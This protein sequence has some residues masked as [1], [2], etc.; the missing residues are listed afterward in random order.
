M[1]A[2]L[3]VSELTAL[4]SVAAADLFLIADDDASASKKVTLTNLEG[5]FSLANLG[6]RSIDNL[7]DV[8]TSG[9]SDGQYL[10]WS[11]SNSR[12]EPVNAAGSTVQTSQRS[13]DATHYLTFVDS[14]N[15]SPADESIYTD[16]GVTYNPSSNLLT[17]GEVSVTTLDIGG[18]DVTA[19]AAE[20]NI[21]DGV[22]ATTAELN[23]LDGVTADASELN[24]LDGVTA[25][26]TELN[27]LDGVTATT[28]ELNYVDGVTS[29]IQTQLNAK[30]ATITAGDGLKDLSD[31]FS[32]DLKTSGATSV[33]LTGLSE[34]LFNVSL[35]RATNPGRIS[36]FG[37]AYNT[38]NTAYF[39][40]SENTSGEEYLEVTNATNTDFNGVYRRYNGF[41]LDTGTVASGSAAFH[42][43][44]TYDYFHKVDDYAILCIYSEE[45]S[46]WVL[47]D[48]NGYTTI[49]DGSTFGLTSP[50]ATEL[51]GWSGGTSGN[52]KN[53]PAASEGDVDYTGGWP[54]LILDTWW[55]VYFA[56]TDPSTWNVTLMILV[57]IKKVKNLLIPQF[58][59][60]K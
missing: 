46:D 4:S 16:A 42:A 24:I 25:T 9:I 14:D 54:L 49:T 39:Y 55:Y 56:H 19:T 51:T 36:S 17:V 15:V 57:I 12:F 28:T 45:D 48:R 22:T 29:N 23:I 58:K 1:A 11:N 2:S 32:V 52:S 21:L 30:Q 13:T 44:T 6:T 31:T 5:S 59:D 60:M 38:G 7:S 37:F 53:Q 26:S 18:T 41:V 3:K 47:V 50:T 33:T 35:T 34:S 10:A 8:S 40:G 20:L 27:I 43:D